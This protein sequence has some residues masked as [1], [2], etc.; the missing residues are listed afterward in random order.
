MFFVL[1][2]FFAAAQS[3]SALSC[4][5][6]AVDPRALRSSLIGVPVFFALKTTSGVRQ[7]VKAD[8]DSR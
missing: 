7:D 8:G 5:R 4:C 3:S 2:M 1:K 6:V